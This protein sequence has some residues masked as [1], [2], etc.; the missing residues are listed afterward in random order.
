MPR[1]NSPLHPLELA[2]RRLIKFV[3]NHRGERNTIW[4][5]FVFD[6]L[7]RW[8]P[9]LS[10]EAPSGTF[11]VS[12]RDSVLGRMTF[13]QRGFE[14]GL[15]QRAV[16]LLREAGC[17]LEG[18][19]FVDVGANIG[20]TTVQALSQFKFSRVVAIEPSAVNCRLLRAN[21]VLN[22]LEESVTLVMAAASDT[23][24]PLDLGLS[25]TNSGD[26]RVVIT[27]TPG[28]FGEES[29]ESAPV[30]GVTLDSLEIADP[31]LIWMDIQGFEA[32]A[33]AGGETLSKVPA[34]VEYWPYALQRCG[35][36][37]RFHR[38][39]MDRYSTVFDLRSGERMAPDR[40]DRLKDSYRFSQTDLLLLP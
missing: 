8:T 12:T 34:V 14:E 40:I 9:Y 11:L 4:R 29:W 15:M 13:E 36:L 23:P 24:Q 10:V 27:D 35:D 31:G 38:L 21:L 22:D 5:G 39:V 25:P 19:T 30:N 32:R 33:L 26:H 37:E 16:G 17:A 20:T 7:S 28:E 18:T 3:I 1:S 2:L 6:R